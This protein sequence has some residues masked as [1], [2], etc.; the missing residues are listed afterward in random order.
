M[1]IYVQENCAGETRMNVVAINTSDRPKNKH[2]VYTVKL[3][4]NG[5]CVQRYR[6]VL[7]YSIPIM[8]RNIA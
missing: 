1:C 5:S 2:I 6:E 3:L 4:Y 7:L 8:L